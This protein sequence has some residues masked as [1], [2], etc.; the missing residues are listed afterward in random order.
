MLFK[1]ASSTIALTTAAAF[2]LSTSA[3]AQTMVGEQEVSDEDLA[4]VT[5]HCEMLAGES[6]AATD[7]TGSD[8]PAPNDMAT[9]GGMAGEAGSSTMT[10]TEADSE[11]DAGG[12]D[13]DAGSEAETDGAAATNMQA[14]D[15][16]AIDIGA[17][18]LEDCQEA[19]L[20]PI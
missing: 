13:I 9:K 18:M 4:M 10:D 14:G 16:D 20:A 15:G 8:A 2:A 17:I 19:G 1:T 6:A 12:P 7:A 3:F 11:L 5:E